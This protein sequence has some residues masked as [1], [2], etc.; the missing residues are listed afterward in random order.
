MNCLDSILFFYTQDIGE[1]ELPGVAGNYE[2]HKSL[3]HLE[4]KR[5]RKQ[6]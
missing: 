4:A 2:P 3:L 1:A 6:R 5:K